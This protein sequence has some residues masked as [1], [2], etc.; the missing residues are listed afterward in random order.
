MRILYSFA[1]GI[2]RSRK[3][4]MRSQNDSAST[5]PALVNG[6][7]GFAS[8]SFQVLYIASPRPGV[9]P[10]RRTPRMLML[11]LIDGM[12]TCAQ[13]LINVCKASISRSR[14]GLWAS[15]IAGCFSRSMKLDSRNGGAVQSMLMLY[16]PARSIMRLSSSTVA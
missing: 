13:F 7:A 16:L 14:S 6:V 11:Y 1:T 2:T 12:P 15:M 10:V 5:W 3:Y 9:R 4:V 8:E